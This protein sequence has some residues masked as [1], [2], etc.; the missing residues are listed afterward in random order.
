VVVGAALWGTAGVAQELGAPTAAPPSVAAVR[1][2]GGGGVLLLVALVTSGR[3]GLTDTLRRGRATCL[4]AAGAM[5]VFQL[6]YLGAVR[7]VGVAIGVLVAIGSAP[8]WAGLYDALRGR[9]PGWRWLVA[10]ILSVVAAGLLLLPA[11]TDGIAPSGV[12]LALIAGLAY[13]TYAVA[14]KH[15]LDR[16]VAGIPVMGVAIFGGGLLLSPALWRNDLGWMATPPGALAAAWLALIAIGASYV[17]FVWGLARLPTP[18]V[19]TL[20]LTEPLV[21]ALLAVLLLSERLTGLPLLGAVLLIV[22]LL[23]VSVRPPTGGAPV[24]PTRA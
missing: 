8:A 9:F 22:G 19:T 2:L 12:A 1:T 10:T 7:S 13:A 21:A 6:G 15:L 18:V 4:V 17:A 14:S 11:G 5:A 20:T 24:P 16:G 23:L 3:S